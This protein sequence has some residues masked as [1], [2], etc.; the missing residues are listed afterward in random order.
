MIYESVLFPPSPPLP[1]S[2]QQ[3]KEVSIGKLLLSVSFSFSFKVHLWLK[4]HLQPV[5]APF[6]VP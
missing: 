1:A 6:L 2:Y 4:Y 3:V 5:S